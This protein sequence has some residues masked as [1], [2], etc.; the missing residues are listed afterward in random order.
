MVVK[1]ANMVK[2]ETLIGV[3]IVAVCTLLTSDSARAQPD[4]P[5]IELIDCP[6][7]LSVPRA[8]RISC[9]RLQVPEDR[10]EPSGRWIDVFVAVVA[11][12]VDGALPPLLY[13]AGGPGDAASSE[14]ADWLE[15]GLHQSQDIIFVD[16]RGS[17]RSV[18]T[19]NCPEFDMPVTDRLVVCRDRLLADGISLVAYDL[20]SITSD[21]VDLI[22]AVDLQSLNIYGFSFGAR[23]AL[24]VTERLPER[25]NALVLDSAS[26]PSD[27]SVIELALANAERALQRVFADCSSD[28]AC[29]HAYPRLQALFE[30]VVADMN[31]APVVLDWFPPAAEL[32]LDGGDLLRLLRAMLAESTRL[33]FIPAFVSAVAEGDR[34]ALARMGALRIEDD[35]LAVDDHSEGLYM[36]LVCAEVAAAAAVE[37]ILSTAESMPSTYVPLAR[38]ALELLEDCVMWNGG[39][40]SKERSLPASISVPTLSLHGRYDPVAGLY[41]SALQSTPGWRYVDPQLGHGVLLD[42]DCAQHITLAFLSDPS[43]EPLHDCLLDL[44]PLEFYIGEDH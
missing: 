40:A 26:Y 27:E 5:T 14:I 42:S 10:S 41:G 29:A 1:H 34:E 21:I 38:S 19:L 3:L 39:F 31:R 9:G 25:V 28:P 13:L 35:S 2:C 18:P 33:P 32:Q 24:R 11:A 30:Q 16:Q 7:S 4:S 22:M 44:Q 8:A 15:A 36:S 6:V 20:D 17:G 23:L 12:E 37:R 43:T